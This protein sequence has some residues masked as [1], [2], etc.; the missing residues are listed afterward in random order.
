MKK[1]DIYSLKCVST[2]IFVTIK[3]SQKIIGDLKV[4]VR[5]KVLL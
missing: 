4:K 1:I 2:L 3:I 5:I